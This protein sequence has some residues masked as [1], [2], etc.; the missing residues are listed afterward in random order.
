M[1]GVCQHIP[2]C[3]YIVKIS[4]S[5]FDRSINKINDDNKR[6]KRRKREEKKKEIKLSI[7]IMSVCIG[8]SI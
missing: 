1:S 4:G 3:H 6:D 8:P 7:K 5:N 2:I